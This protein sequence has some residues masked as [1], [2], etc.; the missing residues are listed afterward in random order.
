RFDAGFTANGG[1]EIGKGRLRLSPEIR[2]TRWG[3]DTFRN[4]Y[5]PSLLTSNRNEFGLLVGLTF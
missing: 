4:T 3:W 2:Y 1:V 5:T